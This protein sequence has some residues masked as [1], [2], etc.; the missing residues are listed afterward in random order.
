MFQT[1]SE[2]KSRIRYLEQKVI[3]LE[4][5]L[6]LSD[7]NNLKKCC[8]IVCIGCSHAVWHQYSN[9]PKRVIGCDVDVPCKD[10]SRAATTYASRSE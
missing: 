9:F 5:A 2:L 1:R 7:E 3:A 6:K 8:G 10:F 4:D